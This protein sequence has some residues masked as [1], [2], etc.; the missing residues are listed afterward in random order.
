MSI[1][2]GIEIAAPERTETSSGSSGRRSACRSAPRAGARARRPR[3][4][5]P[6]G[7]RRVGHVRAAGVGRDREPGRTGSPS[8]SSRRA[9]PPCRRAARVR[10]RT[11]RRS[12]RRIAPRHRP[13]SI[14][15]GR[16]AE[17]S[18]DRA[19]TSRVGGRCGGDGAQLAAVAA[20][21]AAVV[22]ATIGSA[23]ARP[24]AG[25]ATAPCTP[26][27][28]GVVF[29]IDDSGSN[30]ETD[31]DD[32]RAEAGEGRD[33]VPARRHGSCPRSGSPTGASGFS[34]TRPCAPRSATT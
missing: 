34:A 10:R 28:L 13:D 30:T 7:S 23:S 6:A 29:V 18:T 9:R 16:R 27:K 11:A 14:A 31:P 24:V 4:S 20:C 5:S 26:V 12:R 19:T 22:A 17:S 32:L 3:P 33:V 15:G 8:A 21:A 2:P 1:I 25:A